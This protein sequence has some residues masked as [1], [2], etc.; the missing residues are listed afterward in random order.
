MYKILCG[1]MFSIYLSRS[2]RM[3]LLG[4]MVTPVQPL[5]KLPDCCVEHLH[6]VTFPAALYE[7][8]VSDIASVPVLLLRGCCP[9]RNHMQTS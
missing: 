5:K 9:R 1:H 8:M 3:E 2:L 4:Y 7:L 6:Q